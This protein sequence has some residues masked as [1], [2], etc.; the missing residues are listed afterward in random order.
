MAV[1][2]DVIIAGIRAVA[3]ADEDGDR[4]TA[5]ES[6]NRFCHFQTAYPD[7]IAA[8]AHSGR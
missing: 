2:F 5:L 8:E 6:I 1:S 7:S 4:Q 3:L